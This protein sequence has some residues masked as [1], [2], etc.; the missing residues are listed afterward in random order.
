MHDHVYIRDEISIVLAQGITYMVANNDANTS[1]F[2]SQKV[3]RILAE[4]PG[5][6]IKEIAKAVDVNRQFMAG[7]LTAMEENGEICS[8]KVGPA[9]IYFNNEVKR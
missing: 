6:S 2:L 4:N 1:S 5:L 3:K 9:R 8:R 7:F